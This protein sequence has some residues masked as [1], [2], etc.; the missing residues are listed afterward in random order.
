[1]MVLTLRTD[2]PDAEI[3][4]YDDGNLIA[5]EMWLAHRKLVETIH[6]QVEQLLHAQGKEWSDLQGIVVFEGPGSF[7]GLRIGI[8]T[9]NA[10]AYSL[11]IPIVATRDEAWAT[12]GVE[13]LLA[14]EQDEIALPFYGGD[15]NI[16]TPR[17]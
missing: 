8:S 11:A 17:K 3:A 2:K 6:T 15:A 7:T 12:K 9:A 13:R 14:G 10:I 16:T 4:L 1:M 5:Q